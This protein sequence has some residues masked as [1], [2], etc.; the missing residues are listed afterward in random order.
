MWPRSVAIL[1]GARSGYGLVRNSAALGL[2][3]IAIVF[4]GSFASAWAQTPPPT[5]ELPSLQ[6]NDGE[7]AWLARHP[8]VRIGVDPS[9]AP[10]AFVDDQGKP[11]GISAEITALVAR[12]LGI[13]LKLVPGLSWTQ[14]LEAVRQREIDLVTTA[15]YRPER[16]AFLAFSKPYLPTPSVVMTRADAARLP[17]VAAL[18]GRRVALVKSYSSSQ[19]FLAE[20]PDAEPV[21][22]DTPVEGLLAVSIGT[23]DAYIGVIGINTYLA[24]R[25]GL[26][27]L[28]V[29]T[30]YDIANSQSYGVRKDWAPL[31]PLLDKALA[32][33]P[34]EQIQA[35]FSRWIPVSMENLTAPPVVLDAQARASLARL[36]VLKVGALTMRWPFDFVQSDGAHAGV[37]E[38]TLALIKKQ[39][40]IHTRTVTFPSMSAMMDSY[41]AGQLDLL[42]AV[43]NEAENAPVDDLSIPYF[44]SAPGVFVR[45][46][47]VFLGNLDAL[48]DSRVAV[49]EGGYAAETLAAYPRIA[50]VPFP[51]LVAA[52][53]ALLNGEVK[54]MAAETTSALKAIDEASIAGLTYAGPL[55]DHAIKL[56]LAVHPRN[57]GLRP[58]LNAAIDGITAEEAA[59]VRRR[60]VGSL[61]QSGIAREKVR[62]WAAALVALAALGYLAFYL[63]NRRLR[64]EI[65]L[66]AQMT[67]QLMVVRAERDKAEQRFR[68]MVDTSPYAL[69]L[70]DHQGT[71]TQ[72]TA[73]VESLFGYTRSELIGQSVE[74]LV[75]P[76]HRRE[77]L[78]LSHAYPEMAGEHELFAQH[79]DG[80]Q[81][82]VEVR[83]S[84]VEFPEG[85]FV[86]VS[87]VDNTESHAAQVKLRESEERFR[88]LFENA[89]DLI[90][91]LD[92]TNK[93][94]FV[95]ASWC[96]TLGYTPEEANALDLMA[97][98]AP[99]SRAYVAAQRAK[100][101]NGEDLI[102]M[103]LVLLTKDK[104]RIEV[105]GN[106]SQKIVDGK[107]V[108]SRGVF[109]DVT[110]RN[111]F[112]KELAQA[113]QKAEAADHIKSAFLASMSHELR[114][115]LNSVIGFTGIL[116]KRLAGPL[117]D[118]QAFQM[119]KV[120]ESAH[121]LLALVNDVLDIS[122]IEAGELRVSHERFDLNASIAKAMATVQPLADAKGLGLGVET[123]EPV[124]TAMGDARRTAQVLL[125]LLSNAIK[126]TKVGS[127]TLRVKEVGETL[128]QV[129]VSDTGIGIAP[130]DLPTLFQPFRQIDNRL[131]RQ[132]E[133]SGLGLAISRKLAELMDG[134]LEVSSEAGVG[135]TFT[136]TIPRADSATDNESTEK[137]EHP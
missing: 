121:H 70:I 131:A 26:S 110:A 37:S 119:E 128:L 46:G 112:V 105:E 8:V 56:H 68:T 50:Q 43:N 69:L 31:A 116:L 55:S 127:V 97:V 63:H 90:H 122:R 38:D 48:L 7:R 89:S 11:A 125:N 74:L 77:Y 87:V 91:V 111:R 13:E 34:P 136:F 126:F 51:S 113:K 137:E 16:D 15:A 40:G 60:W 71:V 106:I 62:A 108:S 134:S 41:Q 79:K 59:T 29:N 83:L 135:S 35:I 82:P 49:L 88:D 6:L 99:E 23:A 30:T 95:N 42:Y 80:H 9:Y 92:L 52:S 120:R 61:V 96:K 129:D 27:N 47:E 57:A 12:Q 22:V 102:Q 94:V 67:D 21:Y 66:R 53:R 44:V 93:F 45:R 64:R 86:L 103:Q 75:P 58:M 14:M 115:P 19:A 4:A 114:T 117:N 28:T 123:S 109:R 33:I 20:V 133:G 124:G 39:T 54:Y 98:I 10:Y 76:E 72:V 1:K 78:A 2:V 132:H 118:E 32:S 107:N 65:A 104:Q 130:A 73:S 101:L 84:P 5:A 36:P 100:S 25:S 17:G 81:I 18:S 85:H 24:S 3:C